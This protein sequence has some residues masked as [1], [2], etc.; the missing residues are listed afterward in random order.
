MVVVCTRQ[1]Q[2]LGLN[3]AIS[4]C[5]LY[6]FFS[7]CLLFSSASLPSTTTHFFQV[8]SGKVQGL[9][10]AKNSKTTYLLWRQKEQT[11]QKPPATILPLPMHNHH[12]SL[13][14]LIL[15]DFRRQPAQ[16][17][18]LLSRESAKEYL[19]FPGR[20]R[21]ES[22]LERWDNGCCHSK[23]AVQGQIDQWSDS[24]CGRFVCSYIPNLLTNR[25]RC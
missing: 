9:E 12:P 22:C 3:S 23:L 14:T 1:L 10:L 17:C 8:I 18:L 5:I 21:K 15:S 19:G 7:L 6:N 16:S 25:K 2:H 24:G 11:P 13:N 4:L 20:A